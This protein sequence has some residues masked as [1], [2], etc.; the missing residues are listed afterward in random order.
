MVKIINS[1]LSN[2]IFNYFG[3]PESRKLLSCIMS[4]NLTIPEI[5]SETRILKSPAYRKIENML[6]DGLIVESG[7]ILSNNK[8]VSQYRCL[9]KEVHVNITKNKIQV[10]IIID[11]NDIESSSVFKFGVLEN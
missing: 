10:E 8:R 5:L 4:N 3:D 6:L 9:F 7:K 2:K 11:N 1:K